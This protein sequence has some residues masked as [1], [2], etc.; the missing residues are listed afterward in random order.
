M[1]YYQLIRKIVQKTD[2]RYYIYQVEEILEAYK[3]VLI[4][5]LANDER[6]TMI[7]FGSFHNVPME[8]Y[9]FYSSL[10]DKL[11]Y[12]E[13]KMKVKWIPSKLFED[14]VNEARSARSKE[15]ENLESTPCNESSI[16]S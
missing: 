8:G 4:D 12:T 2:Q 6:V 1:T 15:S 7:G 3:Q 11:Y 13:P 9:S 5:T 14:K 16:S 10:H